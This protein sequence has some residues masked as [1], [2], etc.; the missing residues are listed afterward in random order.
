MLVAKYNYPENGYEGTREF[1]RSNLKLGEEYEV[2]FISMGQSYTSIYL[3]GYEFPFNSVL[4]DFYE[5][6]KEVNIYKSPKYNC[7][8]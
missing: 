4:F 7:Y 1:A 2:D 6:G 8:L 3:F 5:D